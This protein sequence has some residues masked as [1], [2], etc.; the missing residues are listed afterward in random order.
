LSGSH[1]FAAVA[2][3]LPPSASDAAAHLPASCRTFFA[4]ALAIDRAARPQSPAAFLD[5]LEQ[6]L[7]D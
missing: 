5:G 1:P 4:S 6:S 2:V 7:H 3:G